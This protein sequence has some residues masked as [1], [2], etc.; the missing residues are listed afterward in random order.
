MEIINKI[1][2]MKMGIINRIDELHSLIVNS[3][4]RHQTFIDYLD[5]WKEFYSDYNSIIKRNL[6]NPKLLIT[7]ATIVSFDN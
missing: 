5:L 7:V 2:V 1:K 3:T 4:D 6:L